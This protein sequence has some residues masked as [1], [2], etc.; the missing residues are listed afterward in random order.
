M[1]VLVPNTK[2]PVIWQELK[3]GI[4]AGLP[5]G[6]TA[7]DELLL[8]IMRG[9]MNNTVRI[10]LLMEEDGLRMI[11]TTTM[12]QDVCSKDKNLLIYSVYVHQKPD[13][14]SLLD[15]FV[16]LSHAAKRWGC[17]RLAMYTQDERV[18]EV[19]RRLSGGFVD[20]YVEVTL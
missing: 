9:A 3:P 19:V 5:R 10:W 1:L 6:V 12:T 7:T 8:N 17:K 16:T 18:L 11:I 15:A 20:T 14:K 2:V 13:K 4:A